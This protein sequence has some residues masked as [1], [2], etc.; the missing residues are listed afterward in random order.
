ME[1]MFRCEN[2]PWKPRGFGSSHCVPLCHTV[3]EQYRTDTRLS[4][5]EKLTAALKTNTTLV[6][7]HSHQQSHQ[8]QVLPLICT[9]RSIYK[10]N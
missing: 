4:A 3:M 5:N 9:Q 6:P 2:L 10:A 1:E 8:A 7:S